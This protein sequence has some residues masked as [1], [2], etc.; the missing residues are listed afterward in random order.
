LKPV[1]FIGILEF[2]IGKNINYFSRHKVLDVETR[3]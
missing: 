2:E 3:E 1:Y